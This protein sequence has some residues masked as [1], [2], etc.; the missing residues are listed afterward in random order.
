MISFSGFAAFAVHLTFIRLNK[1]IHNAHEYITLQNTEL[2]KNNESK[3]QLF[4]IN[5]A[6]SSII[7]IEVSNCWKGD[8]MANVVFFKFSKHSPEFTKALPLDSVMLLD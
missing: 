4:K 5:C 3:N 8:F 6:S 1:N 7:F 2:K